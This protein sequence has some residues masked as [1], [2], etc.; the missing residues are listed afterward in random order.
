M[1]TVNVLWNVFWYALAAVFGLLTGHK[2]LVWMEARSERLTEK[3]RFL[4]GM[5]TGVIFVLSLFFSVVVAAGI[6][7]LFHP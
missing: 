4:Y 5:L 3:K 6:T 7:M 1:Q 2:M